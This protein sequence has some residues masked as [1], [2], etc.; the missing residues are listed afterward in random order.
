MIFLLKCLLI[1]LQNPEPLFLSK[2][3]Q[4]PTFQ[5]DPTKISLSRPTEFIWT[6]PQP[7]PNKLDPP[8]W[9]SVSPRWPCQ[10]S[11]THCKYFGP[12]EF[13]DWCHGDGFPTFCYLL[14]L[15]QSH[16]YDAISTTEARFCPTIAHQTLRVV[17]S[18]S[19]RDLQCSYLLHRSVPPRF[20][21]GAT[22]L[23]QKCVTIGFRVEAIYTPLPP[24]T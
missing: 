9:I 18:R 23:S 8:I 11:R 7:N 17:S 2:S 19:H 15:F 21:I 10:L 20:L 14:H 1:L 12:T 22:E 4:N 16:R 13:C 5:L 24:L 6:L 3:V